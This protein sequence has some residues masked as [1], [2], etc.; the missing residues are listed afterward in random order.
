[1]EV[2]NAQLLVNGVPV[3]IKGANRH[4][5]H[6]K[7]GHYI[8]RET[9]EKDVRLMKQFNI[10]AIRTCHYPCDPY[11]Y[12][13]CD[14]YGIYVVDEANIESHGL[15]AALQNVI[16]P[17]KHIACDPEWTDIHLDRMNRMFQ[18]DKNHPSVII[19]SMGN[20]CGDGVNFVKGYKML[21]AL[22]KSRLVQF[23]QA[24]T[25]PHTDIYCPMYML[26]LIHI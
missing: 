18:R 5:H 20:E 24:G 15:G 19:W 9:M 22:D 14:K 16:D 3:Y 8:P 23:E 6:P 13:L 7:Y 17:Q 25:L 26:S 10:N 4:E 1:M 11:F 21:K 12:E 2:A